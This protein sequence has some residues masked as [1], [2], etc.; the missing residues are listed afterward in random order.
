M[1]DYAC[2]GPLIDALTHDMRVNLK[3]QTCIRALFAVEAV[4]VVDKQGTIDVKGEFII[5]DKYITSSAQID[6]GL[7]NVFIKHKY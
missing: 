3:A 7:E 4:D 1:K 6:I 5:H 2:R